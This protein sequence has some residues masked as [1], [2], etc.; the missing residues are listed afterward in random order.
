[1]FQ[2]VGQSADVSQL[3]SQEVGQS[4]GASGRRAVS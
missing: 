2:E 3:M 1:M 4:A